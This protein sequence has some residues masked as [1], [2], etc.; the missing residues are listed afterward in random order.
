[1]YLL[2]LH[3]SASSQDLKAN[4]SRPDI[5]VYIKCV[6]TSGALLYDCTVILGNHVTSLHCCPGGV[7]D[8]DSEAYASL[9]Q[10][11]RTLLS[12]ESSG[13]CGSEAGLAE[14]TLCPADCVQTDPV[15]VALHEP[16]IHEP[17]LRL[18]SGL[19]DS[20]TAQPKQL[21]SCRAKLKVKQKHTKHRSKHKH[22]YGYATP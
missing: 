11:Q 5:A 13:P 12:T 16:C 21:Q 18:E 4:Q 19:H 14:D 8:N 10:H 7:S 3:G 2:L 20:A 6:F 1:M 9:V 15:A 22:P 17:E